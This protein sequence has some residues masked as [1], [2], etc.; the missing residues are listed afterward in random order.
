MKVVKDKIGL[1]QIANDAYRIV[2]ST[3]GEIVSFCYKGYDFC[4]RN[5]REGLFLV[6]LRDLIGKPVELKAESF[7]EVEF[8]RREKGVTIH[9]SQST[10]FDP[11]DVL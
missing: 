2:F 1:V 4:A 10:L 6:R 8:L 11:V 3:K 9:F 7:Q 5:N